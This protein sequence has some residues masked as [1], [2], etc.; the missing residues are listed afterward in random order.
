MNQEPCYNCGANAVNKIY[1]VPKKLNGKPVCL[2]AVCSKMATRTISE[3][4]LKMAVGYARQR[5][6]R[7]VT[8]EE[9]LVVNSPRYDSTCYYCGGEMEMRKVANPSDTGEPLRIETKHVCVEC[10]EW[11]REVPVQRA[12]AE[13]RP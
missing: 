13:D 8:R 3:M 12:Q 1:V 10:D 9:L 11:G 4:A 2:C 7:K 6:G 5:T